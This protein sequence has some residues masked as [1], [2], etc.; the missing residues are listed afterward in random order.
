MNMIIS[1]SMLRSF[2]T[3]E[4]GRHKYKLSKS[5]S[6]SFKSNFVLTSFELKDILPSQLSKLFITLKRSSR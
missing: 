2:K 1:Y 3:R 5:L 6:S 4:Y